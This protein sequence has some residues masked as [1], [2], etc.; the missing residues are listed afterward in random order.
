MSFNVAAVS[1]ERGIVSW[2]GYHGQN[3]RVCF[4]GVRRK[5]LTK[6]MGE[7]LVDQTQNDVAIIG[8]EDLESWNSSSEESLRQLESISLT[9][10]QSV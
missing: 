4:K 5:P 8:S 6:I 10:K 2:P 1:L 7:L 9:W 3:M